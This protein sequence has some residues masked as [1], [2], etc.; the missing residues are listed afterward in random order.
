MLKLASS[1]FLILL[2]NDGLDILGGKEERG[3]PACQHHSVQKAAY[4]MEQECIS[5][6][7]MGNPHICGGSINVEPYIAT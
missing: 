4:T 2:G 3:H 6:H 7:G 1:F 5:A